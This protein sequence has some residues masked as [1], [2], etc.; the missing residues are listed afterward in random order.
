[1]II[2]KMLNLENKY[3]P[4]KIEDIFISENNKKKKYLIG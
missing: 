3:K 2:Y 4:Q 1:M